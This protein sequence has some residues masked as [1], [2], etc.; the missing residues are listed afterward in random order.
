MLQIF[1]IGIFDWRSECN[2]KQIFSF[3][4]NW[5]IFYWVHDIFSRIFLIR[6]YEFFH[7]DISVAKENKYIIGQIRHFCQLWVF[8]KIK[9][10]N[11]KIDIRKIRENMSWAW[12]I[13]N[14]YLLN[15]FSALPISTLLS[16]TMATVSNPSQFKNTL[17]PCIRSNGASKFAWKKKWK[18]S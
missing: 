15:I 7:Q 9:T 5:R 8:E 18:K 3:L 12:P 14:L 1:L 2:F 17:F 13:L 4:Q 16:V 11:S 6:I 10:K